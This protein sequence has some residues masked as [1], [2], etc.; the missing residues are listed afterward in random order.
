M[1]EKLAEII[2]SSNNIVF[3][4]GAGVSTESNIP[5]FRSSDGLYNS[6]NKYQWPAE[7]MLSYTFFMTHTE[8]FYEF[9]RD[10]IIHIDAKPNKAHKSLA[11][12]EK[13][14]KLKSVITQNID[15]LHQSAGSDK[16]IEIHGS[17]LNNYCIKC[18]T[19]YNLEYILDTNGVPLCSKCGSLVRPDVT[20]YEE[21][22]DILKLE[23]S[24]KYISEADVL[25]VGGTSLTVYPA[26]GLI[27]YYKGEKL[28]LINRDSTSYDNRALLT[29]RESI[30]E[31][32]ADA[33]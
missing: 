14:G 17:V 7:V 31:T 32:L 5:D 21:S 6:N 29:I 26:A 1:N 19:R 4:G 30:G 13:S 2:G 9:Y 27:D 3:F 12:L 16:V 8:E 18:E 10:K 24:I 15:G 11:G 22:L 20:L 33:T 28:V 23:E 25:I